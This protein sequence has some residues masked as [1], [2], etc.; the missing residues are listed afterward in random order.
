MPFSGSEL[1]KVRL[2]NSESFLIYVCRL[3]IIMDRAYKCEVNTGLD[4]AKA[5]PGKG[6]L[7]EINTFH[8]PSP[9]RSF[10]SGATR[11]L[12]KPAKYFG[13]SNN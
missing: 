2:V 11:A 4:Y 8:I 1:S 10:R 12:P 13:I 3:L 5:A 7:R 6:I 9:F